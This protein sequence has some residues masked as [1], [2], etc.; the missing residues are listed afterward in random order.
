MAIDAVTAHGGLHALKEAIEGS[1]DDPTALDTCLMLLVHWLR[2]GTCCMQCV[3]TFTG[4]RVL[5][6]GLIQ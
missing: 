6:D 1:S 5:F 3:A 2:S 4:D